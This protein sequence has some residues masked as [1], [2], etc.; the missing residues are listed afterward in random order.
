MRASIGFDRGALDLTFSQ[1]NALSA[2]NK[3]YTKRKKV[4]IPARKTDDVG[5]GAGTDQPHLQTQKRTK[6]KSKTYKSIS[7]RLLM[8]NYKKR[9]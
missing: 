9:G 7:G 2:M 3:A 4:V 1:I 6:R 8:N 5:A